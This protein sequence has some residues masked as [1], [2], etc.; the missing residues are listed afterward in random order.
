MS[1]LRHQCRMGVG[2]LSPPRATSGHSPTC[3]W[4]LTGIAVT[5]AA[6][7]LAAPCATSPQGLGLFPGAC[8]AWSWVGLGELMGSLLSP[9]MELETLRL[10]LA[11]GRLVS[12]THGYAKGPLGSPITQTSFLGFE[13]SWQNPLRWPCGCHQHMSNFQTL[14]G[15]GQRSFLGNIVI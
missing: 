15:P 6:V 14:M 9:R 13:S 12:P 3:L 11:Q 5:S 1:S 7:L 10:R 4:T 8:R 2:H